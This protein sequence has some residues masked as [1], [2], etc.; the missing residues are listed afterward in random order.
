VF[1]RV[2]SEGSFLNKSDPLEKDRKKEK[3]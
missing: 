2:S 3:K 1:E